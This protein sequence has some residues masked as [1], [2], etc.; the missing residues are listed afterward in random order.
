MNSPNHV[1][2]ISCVLAISFLGSACQAFTV[3][4]VEDFTIGGANWAD[5]AE[6]P[7]NHVATG[8]P[9]NDAYISA[10][11][12]FSSAPPDTNDIAVFRAHN[13]Y[14]SSGDAFVG[15]WLMAD[16][17]QISAYFRHQETAP[18]LELTP[19]VRVATSNN[20]PAFAV[21][22]GGPVPAN[23][24]TKVV[25]DIDPS[26]PLLTVE[27]P[28]NFFNS[29]MVSV[30]NIQFG[31]S[32]PESFAGSEVLRTFDLDRVSIRVPEPGSMALLLGFSSLALAVR[33]HGR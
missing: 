22:A 25:F 14:N 21:V 7:V 23:Q 8:G 6:S 17:G 32:F 28:P 16:V 29:T 10:D 24:W 26:N 27:G 11:A 30:G 13:A 1:F 33:K 9:D 12:A 5:N 20:F 3:P 15:D 19:F 2:F 18:G 4:F 31:F